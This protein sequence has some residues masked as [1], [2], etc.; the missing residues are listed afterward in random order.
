MSA[1]SLAKLNND[2]KVNINYYAPE[3]KCANVQKISCNNN[4]L[5]NTSV[6]NNAE[7]NWSDEVFPDRKEEKEY[8]SRI[9]NTRNAGREPPCVAQSS[10]PGSTNT[11]RKDPSKIIN[12]ESVDSS[13]VKD[14]RSCSSAEVAETCIDLS[15]DSHVD[16]SS[17]SSKIQNANSSTTR[18][19]ISRS[20]SYRATRNSISQSNYDEERRSSRS[21]SSEEFHEADLMS[22]TRR[23]N[24]GVV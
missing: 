6:E 12:I 18:S 16:D 23:N 14:A 1:T 15:G 21:S 24:L 9:S 5:H 13:N 19:N 3:E 7:Y 22:S 4:Q 11:E 17:V 10:S 8:N 20:A 2:F